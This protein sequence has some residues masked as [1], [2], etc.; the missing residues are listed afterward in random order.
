MEEKEPRVRRITLFHYSKPEIQKA[1]LD[2]S[3]G[4]EVVPRYFEGFGKR[5]DALQYIS[6][7]IGLAKKG[8]TSFHASEEIW[9]DPLQ[10]NSDW[11]REEMNQ[12]RES[13]DLIIDIDSKYLDYSK[14]ASRL[15][16]NKLEEFGIKNYGIKFSGS[17]GFHIIVS[18]KAFPEEYNGFNKKN[19]FPEWPRAICEF[20][21]W[22]IRI[23]YNKVVSALDINFEALE[24]RTNLSK[25]EITETMC[26]R[27]GKP[28]K[29]GKIVEFKCPECGTTIKRKDFK[30]TKRKL[31]CISDGCFGKFEIA[32][33]EDYYFCE[34]CNTTSINK[35]E[36]EEG[37]KIIYSSSLKKEIQYSDEFST[38]ISANALA[39]LDLV[40]VAPR[41][42]FR[43]PYS[44]H[45][46]TALVSAVITKNEIDKFD[47]LKD[48]QPM[49]VKVRE[50]MP[51][52]IAGEATRLLMNA[53]DWKKK[54]VSEEE[55]SQK[56]S[57]G[58]Y[59][60]INV[61]GVS[62]EMFPRPIKKLLKGLKDGKKRGLFVLI[63][64]FRTLNFSPEYINGKIREWN[65]LNEPPLKEGYVKVQIDW[66]LKQKKQI[67]P[68]NYSNDNFYKDLGL[69]EE[70]PKAKNPISEVLKKV[71]W[72]KE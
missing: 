71:G 69:I 63:T 64:F 3:K 23:E 56:K 12:N 59:E 2:F 30:I 38:G 5:P 48:A 49:D 27:C 57:Y 61:K 46:K 40:L 8:A 65:K 36:E 42:L 67:F 37:K 52:N 58:Q 22:S 17:K 28:S 44:L 10:I 47:P 72:E 41:H 66:H 34:N 31:N 50:F 39:G 45:D 19:M 26:E 18:G 29:K 4:R 25:E 53:L 33:E 9:K 54:N 70:L 51:N 16:L 24:E 55:I 13:W 35:R 32:S 11:T 21:T 1:I 14:I 7:I 60:K 68:P 20:L 43:M 15:I 62:E 6:D